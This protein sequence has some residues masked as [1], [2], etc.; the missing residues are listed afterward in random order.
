MPNRLTRRR[1]LLAATGFGMGAI[2]VA[3]GGQTAST[4]TAP[5]A[6]PA[7]SSA[8]PTAAGAA[9]PTAAS[10]PTTAAAKPTTSAASQTSSAP[11]VADVPRNE[12]LVV[13]VSD[14]VGQ[15]QDAAIANPF[16][17]GA[18]RTGWQFAFEPLF[19]YNCW[20]TDDVTAP[21]G[22]TGKDGEIP[23]LATSYQFNE[24]NDEL[25]IKLRPG[26]TW[27]DGQPFTANDVVYTIKMLKDN[28]PKLN[29]SNDMQ[30]WVKDIVAVDNLTVDIHLTSP[31]PKFMFQYFQWWLDHGFP[32]VPEH[33][34]K[35]QDPLK[36]TNLDLAK[37]WPVTTGPWKLV[38]S[39][40]DQKIWD[41]RDDWWGAKTGFH[42]LPKVKRVMVLPRY[43][44][45][46][47]AQLLV[48]NQIDTGHQL[49]PTDMAAVMKQ[50][51]KVK[52]RTSDASHPWGWIASWP[53]YIGFNDS[54]APWSD[55]DLR[56]AV[57]HTID[58]KQIVD[59]GFQG[60]NLIATLPLETNAA[61]DP[62]YKA[63]SDILQKYPI[64]SFDINKTAQIMQSKGYKKD[65][66][67]FWAKDGKRLPLVITTS[68]GFFQNYLPIVVA[69]LRKGGFDATFKSPQNAGDLQKQGDID[70]FIDGQQGSVRDPYLTMEQF[71]SQYSAPTGQPAQYPFRWVS[72]EFDA[73]VDQMQ[74]LSA[75][76]P[77]F[78]NLYH[79][80]MEL[81][82]PALPTIPLVQD[83]VIVPV[84]TT[85]WTGWPTD[86]SPYT[87]PGMWLRGSAGL[88]INSLEPVTG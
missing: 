68:A 40:P 43:D 82:I 83:F 44:D 61:L 66:G 19:F 20:W 29:F 30:L 50:N 13:S 23:Y 60:D 74:P 31:N 41:R 33:I 46:K 77:K 52:V 84:N 14:S 62:Y 9:Q 27:S 70:A 63:V 32:F 22:M 47:I 11:K 24:T 21:P 1:V 53:Q 67:G 34:F 76:N 85:Y 56:W 64:D 39:S 73:L 25:T 26:V 59:I 88:V 57:N 69:Q 18:Q 16:L 79:Q 35:D 81:W 5:T 45:P 6:A 48:A 42:P 38:Y 54:K 7:A 51:T 4:S 71:R 58:R 3:C 72:K 49:Q 55:P 12:T 86:K 75:D 37:G 80:M 15:M 28:A 2:V 10:A 17:I 78:M 8:A 65:Q 87:L 36:F